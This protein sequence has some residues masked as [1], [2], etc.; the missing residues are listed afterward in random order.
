VLG[1]VAVVTLAVLAWR[2][3]GP[4]PAGAAAAGSHAAA[5]ASAAPSADA[6]AP[7]AAPSA[8]P[9]SEREALTA[10]IREALAAWETFAR[11]A[12]TDDV[13]GA[14]VADGPQ[15]RRFRHEARRGL[16]G[17]DVGHVPGMALRSVDKIDKAGDRRHVVAR[18]ALAD[19]G[20]EP[21]VR[22]WTFVLENDSGTWRVWTVIDRTA[23]A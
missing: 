5:T 18:V 8:P 1:A 12:D 10:G 2:W 17:P 19:A 7:A 4:P 11:S 16:A 20:G 15:F 14:F 13:T 21:D 23:D 9:G 22:E 6:Q 3:L